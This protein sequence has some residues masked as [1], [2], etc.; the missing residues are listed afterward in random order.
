MSNIVA[1]V[2]K[3]RALNYYECIQARLMHYFPGHNQLFGPLFLVS[4]K[5]NADTCALINYRLDAIYNLWQKGHHPT[6]VAHWISWWFSAHIPGYL[7]ASQ[8]DGP[9]SVVA[10]YRRHI[11][12]EYYTARRP[13]F[14]A[15]FE[16]IEPEIRL[17][18]HLNPCGPVNCAVEKLIR[19]GSF[20]PTSIRYGEGQLRKCSKSGGVVANIARAIALTH[21]LK[22]CIFDT[23]VV[24]FSRHVEL[25]SMSPEEVVACMCK[26][27]TSKGLYGA[28][29][30]FIVAATMATT[31][32]YATVWS[33][34]SYRKHIQTVVEGK[35][36]GAVKTLVHTHGHVGS[37]YKGNPASE[38]D[39]NHGAT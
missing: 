32:V 13:V 11:A 2:A 28:I 36:R 17:A 10:L 35:T 19:K 33:N 4:P 15:D 22:L 9:L 1:C 38:K 25:A 26:N 30:R 34:P 24:P 5:H 39:S 29:T 8:H 20:A 23:T 6:G 21:L 3:E 31:P 18:W 7:A 16:A 12:P 37:D 27:G 14:Y